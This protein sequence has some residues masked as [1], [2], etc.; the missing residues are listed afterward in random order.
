MV[1]PALFCH[2]KPTLCLT[3]QSCRPPARLSHRATVSIH[4]IGDTANGNTRT[5]L[6][7]CSHRI[8]ASQLEAPTTDEN[9]AVPP[10]LFVQFNRRQSVIFC[11]G[12]RARPPTSPSVCHTGRRGHSRLHSAS[13]APASSC[14]RPFRQAEAKPKTKLRAVQMRHNAD[15]S[16]LFYPAHYSHHHKPHTRARTWPSK[17]GGNPSSSLSISPFLSPSACPTRRANSTPIENANV[18]RRW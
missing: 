13:W 6:R 4:Q 18:P 16:S 7:V 1:W 3:C 17:S 10:C 12:A 9:P 8:G 5:C 15:E 11:P 14:L 2:E